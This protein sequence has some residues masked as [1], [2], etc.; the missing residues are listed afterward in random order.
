MRADR[1]IQ[2]LLLL[3]ARARITAAELAAELEVSVPTARRDLAALATSGVPVYPSRGRGG[4]WRLV[5]GARTDLTGLT[6]GELVSLLIGLSQD[7]GAEPE[8]VTAVRKLVRAAPAPFR[9]SAERVAGATMRDV[10]WGA[11]GDPAEAQTVGHLQRAIAAGRRVYLRYTGAR[12]QS[13]SEVVPLVVGSRGSHW[14]LLG[15]PVSDD[16][17]AADAERLRTYRVDRIESLEVLP[18]RGSAPDGFDAQHEW[19]R[20]VERVEDLRGTVRATVRVLPWA[21]RPLCAHFAAHAR[22]LEAD[23]DAAGRTLVEVRAHRIDAL[24]E[25]LSGW[26]NVVEVEGPQEVRRALRDLGRRLVAQY[27]D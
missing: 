21:V 20:M 10:A 11:V 24:A 7:A 9:A 27:D 8:R 19:Q 25:Q 17:G 23:A 14:Y 1:L 18:L 5:G 26:A 2:A 13:S 3:Q 4:G 12:A 22:I 16:S 15:A 6:E